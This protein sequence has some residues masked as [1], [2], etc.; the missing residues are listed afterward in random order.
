MS[1]KKVNTQNT[2]EDLNNHL[3]EELERLNDESLTGDAMEAEIRR[4]HAMNAVAQSIIGNANTVLRATQLASDLG[5][6]ESVPRLLL[7]NEGH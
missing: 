2:L 6:V 4:A 5:K 3:F 7:K 1:G